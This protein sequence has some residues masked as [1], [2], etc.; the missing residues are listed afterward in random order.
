MMD[1]PVQEA[2]TLCQLLNATAAL[3]IEHG[4][5][6]PDDPFPVGQ[7]LWLLWLPWQQGVRMASRKSLGALQDRDEAHALPSGVLLA[8]K[9]RVLGLFGR[10][11]A[12]PALYLSQLAEDPLLYVSDMETE[13]MRRLAQERLARFRTLQERF[14]DE[15]GWLFLVKLGLAV[16]EAEQ[17]EEREHLWFEVHT[18]EGQEV[19]ATLI[20]QPYGIA[21]YRE[22]DRDRFALRFLSDWAVFS[23]HG[24]FDPDSIGHL[25]R[26]L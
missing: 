9:R 10:R 25:E 13:R 18:L 26:E 3:F 16:D 17:D 12:S 14:R 7:D 4:P 1:V 19:E 20:N 5:P 23:P 22:G 2:D 6:P 24:R 15:E 21:R 11:F 8:P